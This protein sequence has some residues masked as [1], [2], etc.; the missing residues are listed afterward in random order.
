MHLYIFLVQ[1]FFVQ[2]EEENSTFF[3]YNNP[4]VILKI[5]KILF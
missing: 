2:L 1:D 4:Y 5:I 3:F